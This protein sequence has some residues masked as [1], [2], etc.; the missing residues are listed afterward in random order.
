MKQHLI[1]NG[2]DEQD[3]R[4]I[5]A[6]VATYHQ[7]NNA[8]TSFKQQIELR[9]FKKLMQ[10]ADDYCLSRYHESINPGKDPVDGRKAGSSEPDKKD[11][12]HPEP[13][14]LPPSEDGKHEG[15]V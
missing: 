10:D 3:F 7:W 5:K 14:V 9:E 8:T 15:P 12:D 2:W 1:I 6:L 13:A 4:I 11:A